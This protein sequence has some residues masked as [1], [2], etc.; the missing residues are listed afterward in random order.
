MQ[1]AVDAAAAFAS[2]RMA[3]VPSVC[4]PGNAVAGGRKA[5]AVKRHLSR[6]LGHVLQEVVLHGGE[7]GLAGLVVPGGEGPGDVADVLRLELG[8]PVHHLQSKIDW[9]RSNVQAVASSGTYL[10]LYIESVCCCGHVKLPDW[11]A[12]PS[13]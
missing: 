2:T 10:N 9:Q 1:D 7:H 6:V 8:A 3:M 11:E 4:I 12:A 5:E 13:E